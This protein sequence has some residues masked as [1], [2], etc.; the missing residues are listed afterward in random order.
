MTDAYRAVH[1]HDSDHSW[2]GRSGNGYRTD[3][4]FVTAQHRTQVRG[5]DY[6]HAPGQQGLTDHAAMTLT[7][8]LITG[9]ARDTRP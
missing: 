9:H 3:H 7:L 2:F 4:V 8:T 5:C 6:L 1:P